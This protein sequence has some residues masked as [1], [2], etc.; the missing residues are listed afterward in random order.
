MDTNNK[1]TLT[2]SQQQAFDKLC[3]FIES[4]T[5]RVFI[6]KGY[7]GT[8]KTT[9]MREFIQELQKREL[10]YQL[11]AS[12]GR[13]AKILSN[14]TENRA[15]TVH[16]LIYKFTDLNQ[17]IEEAENLRKATGVDSSGQ[18]YLNF[19]LVP[20][21][22]NNQTCL[23]LVDESSMISDVEEKNPTQAQFGTGK[24]L[25]DL[26]K[27]DSEGKFVFIG[28]TCQ[29]PP[30]TQADSPALSAD[31]FRNTYNIN[32]QE[33]ELT[34]IV[35]QASGN[36]IVQS[37]KRIRTL[38]FNPPASKCAKFPLLGYR[39]IHLLNSTAELYSAYL[40]D[41]KENGFRD[42][43]L[44]CLSN[45]QCSDLTSI[46]RPALNIR[47]FTLTKGDLLLI[48]QNNY[49]SGL[50]NG[51]MVIIESIGTQIQRAGLTF[52]QVEVRELFS[53]KLYSQ[54]LVT[55]IL[56]S[57][58]TNITQ[59]QQKSLFVDFYY[60]MKDK[61][62]AQG[63]EAFNNAMIHDEYLNAIRAVYGYALTCHKAQ[64]GE[65]KRVYLDIP[66][67]LPYMKK[68]YVYQWMYT[69]MTRASEDLYM[70]RDYWVM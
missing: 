60:R 45:K 28:D 57:Q 37:T 25:N 11:V 39:N 42:A 47:E 10:A 41:V 27:Y 32:P 48:T 52:I 29:L 15:V 4:T 64:G 8:G 36:D 14:A 17:N 16:S 68:P 13:A 62:I 49:I 51:D 7:A 63:T 2:K 38:F 54:L 58:Q 46:V 24:L 23:Y 53:D 61:N 9:L 12:T 6:L 5:D 69:A 30:I 19:D 1:I 40:K 21:N 55:D 33:A 26:L 20:V 59:S 43:T 65:W 70:V 50:M 31:Y 66:R 44:L 34:D 3:Q 67:N 18:L 56:Y 35:R 22:N